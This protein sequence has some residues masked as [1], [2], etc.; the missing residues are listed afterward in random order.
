[1]F[2]AVII[3]AKPAGNPVKSSTTTRMSQTW[4]AG[5]VTNNGYDVQGN[6]LSSNRQLLADYQDLKDWSGLE[7]PLSAAP[8]DLN[9]IRSALA[10]VTD[11]AGNFT[12]STT[13]DALNRPTSLTSPDTSLTVPTYNE[14]RLLK[15]VA[16]TLPGQSAA[17]YVGEIEYNAKGQR[18]AISY[19]NMASTAYTYDTATF[20]LNSVYTTRPGGN[21]LASSLV[22][23]PGV[24]QDLH[25][26]YDPVGNITRL[27]DS[28]GAMDWKRLLAHITG[29]VT[30]EL[31]TRNE[32]LAE[33]N[34]ILRNQIKGRLRLSDAERQNL[35]EIGQRLGRKAL[36]SRQTAKN[37]FKSAAFVQ[38][39]GYEWAKNDS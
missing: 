5:A 17:A 16:A 22:T 11:S 18:V 20:R 15:T 34:R 2:N 1:M 26:T 31:L 19:V 3:P 32:Y 25:Y 38:G 39:A 23:N 13:Y 10:L 21:G 36:A 9:G 14:A 27:P 7:T 12:T 4:L 28:L 30:Q 35:A 29:S 37:L 6:L 24:V 33:E 8:L